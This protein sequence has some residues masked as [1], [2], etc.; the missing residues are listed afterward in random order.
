MTGLNIESDVIIEIAS[1]ITSSDLDIIAEGPCLA[2]SQSKEIL[3]AMDD[4]NQEHHTNSGLVK[5]VLESEVSLEEAEAV[6][7]D[8]VSSHVPIHSSPLCGN[9]VWQDRRFLKK[10]MATLDHYLHYRIIDVSTIKELVRR[11]EP[12]M[13]NGL[14]KNAQ[15]RALDDIKESINE[16]RLYRDR[17]FL[18]SSVA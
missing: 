4:W 2:I 9:S 11:W 8:F 10:H 17:F 15:H 6:T 13:F 1:V 18:N 16:L 7:F 12:D 14:K 3:D 5:K